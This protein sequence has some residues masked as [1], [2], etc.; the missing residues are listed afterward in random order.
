MW[1]ESNVLDKEPEDEAGQ[2]RKG[3]YCVDVRTSQ[4]VG[5]FYD[6]LFEPN[7]GYACLQEIS[8]RTEKNTSETNGLQFL[9]CV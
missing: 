3:R 7:R 1:L 4:P 9:L 8:S 6:T 5:S 2:M